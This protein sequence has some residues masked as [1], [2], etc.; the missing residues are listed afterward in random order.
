MNIKFEIGIDKLRLGFKESD[1]KSILGNPD[2]IKS[3]EDAEN[4]IIWIFNEKKIRLTFYRDEEGKLGYIETANPKLKLNDFSIINSNIEFVKETFAQKEIR[5]WEK[6][7]YHSFT[8]YFNEKFWITLHVSYEVVT[9]LEI[10][11]P[12]LTDEEY[13]WPEM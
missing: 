2:S 1:V 8:T 12:F 6:E 3:H 13:K 7:E 9:S 10:G 11:V 5:D 4:K